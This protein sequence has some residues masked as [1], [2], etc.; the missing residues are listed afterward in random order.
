M[1]IRTEFHTKLLHIQDDILIMGS[2]AEKAILRS[3]EALKKR[4][5]DLANRIIAD[6][7]SVDKMRFDIEE[8]CIQLI[9]TQQPMASDLRNIISELERIADHAEG[10]AK[11]VVMIGDEPPLQQLSDLHSMA[12]KTSDM[13]RRSLYTS[14]TATLPPRGKSPWRTMR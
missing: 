9:A 3:A 2:M 4:D 1:R 5:F 14:S 11:I 10:I 13:L 7:V 12:V 8:K 6:N